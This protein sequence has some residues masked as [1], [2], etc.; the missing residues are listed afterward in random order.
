MKKYVVWFRNPK[1]A[2]NTE[3]YEIY[4]ATDKMHAKWLAKNDKRYTDA[5][6]LSVQMARIYC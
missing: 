3:F 5:T 4:H 2:G 6:I 1:Q